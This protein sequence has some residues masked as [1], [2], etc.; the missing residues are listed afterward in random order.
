MGGRMSDD[1]FLDKLCRGDEDAVAR[2]FRAYAPYLRVV[3]RRQLSGGLRAKFDSADVVQSV[4][5]D[6]LPG[7][8]KG[9]WRFADEGRLRAFLARAVRN[10]FLNRRRRHHAS[11]ERER[12]LGEA[13][14]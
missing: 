1:A 9:G 12:A 11:L 10:R 8:R 14:G 2:A 6:L 13:G 7:F 5:A 4:W 3:V